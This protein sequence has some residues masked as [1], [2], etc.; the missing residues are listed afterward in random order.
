MAVA[1]AADAAAMSSF[2]RAGVAALAV[3][4]AAAPAAAQPAVSARVIDGATG[5][6][7]AG[8]TI[9]RE[10]GAPL[11]TTGRDGRFTIPE[12]DPA[13]VLVVLADGYEATIVTA[14]EGDGTELA[15]LPLGLVG[16][17]IE[18]A[19]SGP[20]AAPGAT[21]LDRTE[22]E[23][24]PGARGDLIASLDALPGVTGGGPTG[25]SGVVIRGSAPEDS[26]I[27]VDGFEI[28][29][30]YHLGLRSVIPTAAI[31]GLEY[32]PGGFDVA[33]GRAS[34]GIVSVTTRGGA[35][36][37]GGQAETSVID[38]GVLAQGPAGDD[39]TFLLA[40]RRSVVDLLLPSLI[41]ED[42]DIQFTTVPHY[43]D[44]QARL[45]R[46]VN[47][48]W[49][50]SASVI[51]TRDVA[52]ILADDEDDPDQRF[53]AETSFARLIAD[54]RYHRGPWSATIA[55]SPIVQRVQFELGQS[56]YY[57]ADKA[58]GAVRGEVARRWETAR[59]LRDVELR[60]GAEVDLAR[61]TLDL[62][63]PA[64]EDEGEPEMEQGRPD[65]PEVTFDDAIWVNDVAAWTSLGFAL[66]PKLR[67]QAG[68]RVDGFARSG[69]VAV[70]PRGELSFA[71]T[72]R[73]KLRLVAGAYRRPAEYLNELLDDSL[74]PE[75]ATQTIAGVEHVP[76][77][78]ARV[79]ASVY[80]TDRTALLTRAEDGGFANQGRGTTY[81]GEV[82]AS[83]KR[84][85]WSGFVSY[86]LSRSTRV[87]RPG[88]EERLFDF[89][90]THDLNV[91]GNYKRGAWQLGARFQYT[92]GTPETDVMGAIYDSDRD[93]YVPIN[94]PVNGVRAPAHHQLDV[95]LERAWAWPTWKL[96]AFLDVSNVYLNAP[97]L[98]T[99]YSFDYS[100]R[101]QVEGL[102]ILPSIGLR[103][104]L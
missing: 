44:A 43:W 75:R 8:A 60:A 81:G 66:T 101:A 22:V 49:K 1:S 54:A 97:I 12:L 67:V 11:A 95:R 91:A 53:Y 86:A 27:L 62:A 74:A 88:A 18:L 70:Q 36:D 82:F 63:T 56:I 21:K 58:G 57:R 6:P 52:E 85:P 98:G 90:Q 4:A 100:E 41:P 26:K 68:L 77:D 103:G 24:L 89:D 46:P 37:L 15:L 51:G 87:D 33:Y 96:V 40:V 50:L 39:G 25:F 14:A 5:R 55:V 80:Y 34:S 20:P 64:F 13:T 2:L 10:D 84:G 104:E 61:W 102:P 99:Q 30:L 71:A 23:A 35:R 78:G 73:T 72:A 31:A 92:S 45:D 65:E 59:G 94:G 69:D 28:P 48:R 9:T 42:A 79:Q 32:I 38:S 83:A 17:T 19:D 16:E 29:L 3:C 7:L 93:R 76:W 47:E